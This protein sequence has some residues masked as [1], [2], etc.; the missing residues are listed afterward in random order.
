MGA[1]MMKRTVLIALLPAALALCG[2]FNVD[3]SGYADLG[4]TKS[5]P[6]MVSCD[7]RIIEPAPVISTPSAFGG[8]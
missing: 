2:C 8:P 6:A 5:E 4:K 1:A 7:V 3:V